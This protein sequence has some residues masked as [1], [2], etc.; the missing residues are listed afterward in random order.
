MPLR[1]NKPGERRGGRQKGTPN[2]STASVKAAL[3]MAFDGIGGVPALQKWAKDNP[4]DF[5]GLWS[6]LIP[7][8]VTSPEDGGIIVRIVAHADRN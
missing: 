1:P 7:V 2:K 4:R 3:E 6:K 8:Q 5:Y